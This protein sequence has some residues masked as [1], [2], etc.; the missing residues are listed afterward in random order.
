[1]IKTLLISV[2]IIAIGIAFLAIKLILKPKGEFSSIHI[3]DSQAMKDRGIHCVMDQD[4]EDRERAERIKNK[5]L[6]TKE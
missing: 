5:R 3:H 6:K 2:L 1:M 4:R